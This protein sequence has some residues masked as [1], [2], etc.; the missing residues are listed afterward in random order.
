MKTGTSASKR[1][2]PFGFSLTACFPLQNKTMQYFCVENAH[3]T[4]ISA[5]DKKKD[6]LLYGMKIVKGEFKEE[7]FSEEERVIQKWAI[8]MNPFVVKTGFSSLYS[9]IKTLGKGNFAR[10]QLVEN[11]ATKDRFAVKIFDKKLISSDKLEKVRQ[12]HSAYDFLTC[13][14][15]FETAFSFE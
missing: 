15:E 13:A 3:L 7:F 6:L 5:K 10:V 12:F 9:N 4:T 1:Y 8:A 14:G 2:F 11:K